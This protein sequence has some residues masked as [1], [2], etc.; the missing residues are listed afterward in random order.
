MY[1]AALRTHVWDDEIAQLAERFAANATG[2]RFVVLADETQ[3]ALETGR[4]EKLAHTADFGALGLP[5]YPTGRSL[6]YNGDYPLYALA[7]AFPDHDY[8]VMSEFD[9][10]VNIEVDALMREAA[11]RELDVIAHDIR[12]A[13]EDWFWYRN[14][15]ANYETPYRSLIF[16]LV[17]SRRA[18]EVLRSARLAGASG[19]APDAD[20]PFCETFV[21]SVIAARP[22]LRMAELREFADTSL[23]AFRPHLC[24][25]D[26][27]TRA[28]GSLAHPVLGRRRFVPAVVAEHP[29][30]SW[31]AE[32]SHMRRILGETPFAEVAP[33]IGR[34][35][36]EARDHTSLRRLWDEA[37]ACGT[38]LGLQGLDRADL[39]LLR[40]ALSSSV[41]P[42]SFSQS[43]ALDARGANGVHVEPEHGFH[44]S[45]EGDPWWMVDL[46]QEHVVDALEIV[47]R[48]R[49]SERFRHFRVESSR[50]GTS[51]LTRFLKI[52]EEPVES[53]LTAPFEVRFADPFVARHVRVRAIGL[54]TLHLRKIRVRGRAITPPV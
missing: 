22:E 50:D 2:A 5:E 32:G 30:A 4:F 12:P 34:R 46:E 35:L 36:A 9:V 47:N 11:R 3:G 49:F 6:W 26:A 15:R 10:A 1:V 40:P 31:F 7:D 53:A 29:P 17:V 42:F 37:D 16:F 44:T 25:D 20:W 18:I 19:G 13:S 38:P 27:R 8:F 52:S 41:S 54:T 14:G 28:P 39:A 48:P 24:M 43:P 51:W 33:L 21:P 45:E 23:L